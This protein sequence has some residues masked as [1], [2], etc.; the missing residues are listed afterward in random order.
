MPEIQTESIRVLVCVTGQ[1]TCERLIQEGAHIARQ[2]EGKVSVVHVAAQG[3]TFLGSH[4]EGDALEYLFRAADEVGADMTVL[5]AEDVLDTLVR[6]AR[7]GR[8]DCIVVGTGKGRE[9][10]EFAERLRLRLPGVE[11]RSVFAQ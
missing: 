6:F 1:K 10:G 8:A 4:K 3:E 11:I 7:D 2:L 9:G 5:R